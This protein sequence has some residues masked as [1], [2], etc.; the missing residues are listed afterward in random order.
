VIVNGAVVQLS[1]SVGR[2]T[3]LD[4]NGV[5]VGTMGIGAQPDYAVEWVGT[6]MT[7]L[8]PT[9]WLSTATAI[10]AGKIA[11]SVEMNAG[12]G[13]WFFGGDV[14]HPNFIMTLDPFYDT[15][16]AISPDGT[17]VGWQEDRIVGGPTYW[18]AVSYANGTLTFLDPTGAGA[19][20]WANG[21]NRSE[22]VVGEKQGHAT[23]WINGQQ[24]DLNN[25]IPTG[26]GWT[27]VEAKAINDSGVIVGMGTLNG[28]SR[29]FILTPVGRLVTGTVDLQNLATSP[30]GWQVTID[31]RTPAS[32]VPLESDVVALDPNGAFSYY[33]SL[34]AGV[35]D[36][37]VKAAHWLRRTLPGQTVSDA[38]ISGLALTLLDGDVNGD[39]SISLADFGLLRAA[40]GS[41]PASPNWNANADLNG[42]G[43]VGLADF[44]I[45]RAHFGQQGDP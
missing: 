14:S 22:V 16:S 41:T 28:V 18:N 4:D 12:S 33:A 25:L 21:I 45:L 44:G 36:L 42:D 30:A 35:Y 23:R 26:S 29:P 9:A 11:G 37:S 5:V 3:D 7:Q 8:C 34:P 1:T 6:T 17:A 38:G 24:A 20:S 39:N 19:A 2:V 13:V 15:I 10:G 40:Y 32:T 27:L 31:L 43:T